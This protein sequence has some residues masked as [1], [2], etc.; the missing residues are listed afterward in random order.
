MVNKPNLIT[1]Q[2][3]TFLKLLEYSYKLKA[4]YLLKLLV[5]YEKR[6]T[7]MTILH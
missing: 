6:R 3:C 5:A 2:F 1:Y 7:T 4:K